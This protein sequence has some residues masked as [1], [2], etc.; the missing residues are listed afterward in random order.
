MKRPTTRSSKSGFA[1][2]L[3]ITSLVL[4]VILG[5]SFLVGTSTELAT[6]QAYLKAQESQ[7]LASLVVNVVLA[8]INRATM[9]SERV[10]EP[11]LWASQPG[12]I[13]TW[14]NSG[15]R[16]YKL[17]SSD[18]LDTT[19]LDPTVEA[20]PNNWHTQP[21]LWVDINE[22]VDNTYPVLDATLA[23]EPASEQ[24]EG[25]SI[26][27]AP[28]ATGL[29]ANSAPMPVRWIYVLKDGTLQSSQ[30]GSVTNP[31]VARIAF[32][33]DDESS[34]VNIN[35]ASEGSFWDLPV[36]NTVQ[37]RDQFA[38]RQPVQ[39]EF[40]RYPGHPAAVSLSAVFP[41]KGIAA[42]DAKIYDLIP[43]VQHGGSRG[44]STVTADRVDYSGNIIRL[45]NDLNPLFSSP[46][47]FYF[48]LNGSNQRTP[49]L[50]TLLGA[51][52][53][54][55]LARHSF[56]ITTASS[57]P[58]LTPLG[59]P[60]ISMWPINS[61]N[62]NN[63]NLTPT[64]TNNRVDQFDKTVIQASRLWGNNYFFL[65]ANNYSTSVDAGVARNQ[66]L[67]AYLHSQLLSRNLPP[68]NNSFHGKYSSADMAHLTV[69]AFDWIRSG[70]NL[71]GFGFA[72]RSG[73]VATALT[74]KGYSYNSGLFDGATGVV[75]PVKATLSGQTFQGTGNSPVICTMGY[76][77]FLTEIKVTGSGPYTI[78]Y[79]VQPMVVWETAS[80]AQHI[81]NGSAGRGN[82]GSGRRFL[83]DFNTIS[84]GAVSPG[85][86]TPVVSG[87]TMTGGGTPNFTPARVYMSFD[88]GPTDR[89][90][91]SKNVIFSWAWWFRNMDFT[92]DNN[93]SHS[94][95]G[96]TVNIRTFK[97]DP[98]T[99]TVTAPSLNK[100]S[101]SPLSTSDD[102]GFR[103]N[104][105][106][107]TANFTLKYRNNTAIEELFRGQVNIPTMVVPLPG[108][109]VVENL[110]ATYN[111]VIPLTGPGRTTDYAAAE[112][113]AVWNRD[114]LRLANLNAPG[115]DW[116]LAHLKSINTSGVLTTAS[117]TM[118]DNNPD[119]Y[120][121]GAIY[122]FFG[123]QAD[124]APGA[125]P[126]AGPN[127]AA[128][129]GA[130]L[131]ENRSLL[132][133]SSADYEQVRTNLA[134]YSLNGALMNNNRPG[135][136]VTSHP[137]G[138]MHDGALFSLPL[139]HYG[140]GSYPY[141][142]TSALYASDTDNIQQ[143]AQLYS[144]NRQIYSPF[145]MGGLLTQ[146]QSDRPWQTL[147]F[148]P[149][150]AAITGTGGNSPA[151]AG[152]H[153]GAGNPPDHLWAEF[154]WMPVVDPFPI[155]QTL[156]TLGK[157]NVNQRLVPFPYI[158]RETGLRAAVKHINLAVLPD[159]TYNT[160][161]RQRHTMPEHFTTRVTNE[162][163]HRP[164]DVDRFLN[165]VRNRGTFR[166]ASEIAEIPMIQQGAGSNYREWWS[167]F[168][169]TGD[170]L[171]E[172]PYAHLQAVLT[173]RSNT[174]RIHWRVQTLQV[175]SGQAGWDE[176]RDR[177]LAE[178]RGNTLVERFLDP[179]AP[180]GYV[181]YGQSADNS[182]TFANL[183]PLDR[184]YR[185]RIISHTQFRP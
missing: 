166:T 180:S 160:R 92:G 181:D 23:S 105:G 20:P 76:G 57:A 42:T 11:V 114:V 133:S 36:S 182:A 116:R 170:N 125:T 115:G 118:P 106:A 67:L 65:R 52:A 100:V 39:N 158:R 176:N 154:F 121:L 152:L 146:V 112:N 151:D 71:Y 108:F 168:P 62:R 99:F 145:Q 53:A 33:T 89:R 7:R 174:Y 49:R 101:G 70:P 3:V 69:Q 31:P 35:T 85:P 90:A 87:A 9:Q 22:P 95:D 50:T 46:H 177:V 136:W 128:R 155:S 124:I 45:G 119:R 173:S 97:S 113:I 142:D 28:V 138:Y 147:L 40:Q 51:T 37:D 59:T 17:Y 8:Q 96:G 185:W 41:G 84:M 178:Y 14:S 161:H 27:G 130:R 4:M 150:P 156:T 117:Y 162:Q 44:G 139:D 13:T 179:Q 135:D 144:P 18:V 21:A 153:P 131:V 137:D 111:R 2:V 12:L 63:T 77:L 167:Q 58:E 157:I 94:S 73:N 104:V 93:T 74:D 24:P 26:T 48:G 120:R 86:S 5:V 141:M 60:K 126:D 88:A 122:S 66:K 81:L 134:A 184:F 1:L 68:W 102:T 103:L 172:R 98:I 15:S 165:E 6:A 140:R 91:G 109:E 127:L 64:V 143:F 43:R 19:S 56:F 110:T 72:G 163:T 149:M 171:R 107:F 61:D 25:F 132:Q 164:I 32:W 54:E 55:Q 129:P 47:E 183:P 159:T 75:L 80:L 148:T 29:G 83:I 79:T 16:F 78:T 169:A 175:Q 82:P 38:A 34:K 30:T 123:S 10:S